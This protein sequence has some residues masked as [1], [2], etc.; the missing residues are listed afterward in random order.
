MNGKAYSI[1][2]FKKNGGEKTTLQ[3][4]RET[5]SKIPS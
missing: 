3:G 5:A 2:N 1:N 4:M